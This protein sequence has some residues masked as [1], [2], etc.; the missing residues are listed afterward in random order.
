[1]RGRT[2]RLASVMA[3]AFFVLILA[4]VSAGASPGPLH[5]AAG[6]VG[7]EPTPTPIREPS[8]KGVGPEPPAERP[9][10]PQEGRTLN[11]PAALWD[12]PLSTINH[13]AY[14]NQDFEAS[15]DASD[16]FIADDFVNAVPWN[17]DTIF[18]PGDTWSPGCHLTCAAMLHW[19]IYADAGGV[20]DGNPW[21]GGNAPVWSI[22]LLPTDPQVTLST[23]TGGWLSNVTLSLAA[24]VSLLPGTWWLVF[25]PTMEFG[26]CGQYGRQV[27]DTTNGFD[28]QVINPGGG[29]GGWPTVWT[30]VQDPSTFH[31]TQQDF[32]FRLEGKEGLPPCT[33]VIFSDDFEAGYGNWIG[34]GLWNSEAE[35]DPCGS[36]VA[37]FPSSSHADYYG[38]DGVCTYNTGAANSGTLSLLVPVDLTS[39][40]TAFAS[41]GSYE[42]TECSG[43]NCGFDN[44]YVE[45]ST[46]GGVTWNTVWGSSGPRGSWYQAWVNLSPYAGQTLLLRFRFDSVD[47][48][49]NNYF[50]W[51]V[52]DITVWGSSRCVYLP[53]IL[54]NY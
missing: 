22:S 35:S 18:V 45:V 20:P 7:V 10:A 8:P 47:Q 5:P 4:V 42:E 36:L 33:R 13:A 27:S 37:P 1:M 30:S 34:T 15:F 43:G 14:A 50:G 31:L 2:V 19:Q 41:F 16:I 48:A 11:M 6:P 44:R 38:I 25:Y 29:F 32:A 46:D 3:I 28:A 49:F 54:K 17:I 26:S 40:L 9:S 39:S 21:G 12:Q 23:G 53:L 24:P 51:M 52:D